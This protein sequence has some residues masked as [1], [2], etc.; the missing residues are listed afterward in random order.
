MISNLKLER[1]ITNFF[2]RDK[3]TRLTFRIIKKKKWG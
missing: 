3:D 2:L 1:N